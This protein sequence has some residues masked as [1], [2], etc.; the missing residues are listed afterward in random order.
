MYGL[1]NLNLIYTGNNTDFHI[2]SQLFKIWFYKMIALLFNQN[3]I[4]NKVLR[5]IKIAVESDVKTRHI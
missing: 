1:L 2:Y 3:L 5:K 4:N